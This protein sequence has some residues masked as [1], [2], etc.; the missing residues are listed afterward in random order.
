MK[1]RLFAAP[2][3]LNV[4]VLFS[5]AGQNNSLFIPVPDFSVYAANKT[6][7]IGN[8][9][10][11]KSGTSERGARSLPGWV[12]AFINGG[13]EAVEQIDSYSD[14]Y[15]FIGVNEGDKFTALSKWADNFS[16]E[17]DF[18]M[19]AA[20][21]IEERLISNASLYPDDEYGL[22]FER[23]VKSAYSAEYQ[24]AVKED[25]Y[26]IRH[27]LP[28]IYTFFVLI[29]IDKNT[30]QLIVRRMMTQATAAANPTGSQAASVNRLRQTFFE[31]F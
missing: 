7:E 1:L 9:I 29:T 16:A 11:T 20:N 18:S 22:F 26:W 21:R 12:F 3:L 14:K 2:Y 15:V 24:G 6:T 31:G 28:E 8:I 17:Q 13:I 10:E 30:M 5:C 19:L 23:F 27:S 25:T 4:L